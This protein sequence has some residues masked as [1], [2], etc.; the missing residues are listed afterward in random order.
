MYD[1]EI[2]KIADKIAMSL[3]TITICAIIVTAAYIVDTVFFGWI[4]K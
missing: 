1:T 2:T 3:F 4:V